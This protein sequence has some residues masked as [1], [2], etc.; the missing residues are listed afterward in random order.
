V[1]ASVVAASIIHRFSW[2]YLVIPGAWCW[3]VGGFLIHSA[4]T[5]VIED[6]SGRLFRP[7]A[8][9]RFWLRF[10]LW[11]FAYVFAAVIPLGFALQ[12]TRL[13]H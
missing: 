4:I 10:S 3:F 5:G 12:E 2:F 9:K 13:N 6:N 11:S 8:P 1:V 7:I